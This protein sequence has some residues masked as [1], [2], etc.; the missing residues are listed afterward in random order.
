MFNK[1]YKTPEHRWKS[2]TGKKIKQD[3]FVKWIQGEVKIFEQ[4]LY[5]QNRPIKNV[6]QRP[7]VKSA[8]TL[9]DVHQI[10]FGDLQ[11]YKTNT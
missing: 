5:Q 3:D 4:S 9:V 8:G 1:S 6:E 10:H 7:R 11:K 2:A